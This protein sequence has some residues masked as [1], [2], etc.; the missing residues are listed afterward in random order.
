MDSLLLLVSECTS[1]RE[2]WYNRPHFVDMF[3]F[4]IRDHNTLTEAPTH[5]P[6]FLYLLGQFP[7]NASG[8]FPVEV[9]KQKNS[10]N[11]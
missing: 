2:L 10:Q 4:I 7:E 5:L 9:Q 6:A 1:L 3:N 11:H 8:F